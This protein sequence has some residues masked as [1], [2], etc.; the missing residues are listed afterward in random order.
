MRKDQRVPGFVYVLRSLDPTWFNRIKVGLSVDPI[1]RGRQL[2][3]TGVP[4]PFFPYHVWAVTDMALAERVAHVVLD[5]H[6]LNNSREHF[7]VIPFH[8]RLAVL[9]TLD[10]PA[11]EIVLG[12]LNTLLELIEAEFECS[13]LLGHYSVDVAQLSQYSLQRKRTAE[14]PANPDAFGPLF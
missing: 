2:Y 3:T 10:E 12:C 9:G 7:D 4:F 6:R 8:R 13:S 14:D 1:E 11:D 5:D